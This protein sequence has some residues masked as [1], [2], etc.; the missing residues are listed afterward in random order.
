MSIVVASAALARERR[1]P[2]GLSGIGA[3]A[4][5]ACFWTFG[6]VAASAGPAI[7]NYPFT[8]NPGD[9]ISLAG[10]GFGT[11]P[12]VYLK[13]SLQAAAI[14]LPT[15]TASDGAVVVSGAEDHRLRSL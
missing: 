2:A 4:W 8:A 11:A 13:P 15:R 12:K 7:I 9:V 1:R 10:S 3:L 5:A 14:A 6:A